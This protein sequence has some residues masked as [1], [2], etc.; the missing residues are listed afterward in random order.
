[1]MCVFTSQGTQSAFRGDLIKSQHGV[2]SL[3]NTFF[4]FKSGW[5]RRLKSQQSG[6]RII[7]LPHYL[8]DRFYHTCL[9]GN[10]WLKAAFQEQ[11]IKA[12]LICPVAI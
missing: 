10:N 6:G 8:L 9:V 7:S 2:L 12:P 11:P 5:E 3:R 4:S 1:M